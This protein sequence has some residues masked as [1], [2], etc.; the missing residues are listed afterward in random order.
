M[1]K[2]NNLS[3]YDI[4]YIYNRVEQLNAGK[5]YF[6][7]KLESMCISKGHTFKRLEDKPK[8]EEK[9]IKLMTLQLP[10]LTKF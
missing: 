8:P 4:N 1:C 9:K 6:L 5:Y 7:S 3:A 10:K 2:V